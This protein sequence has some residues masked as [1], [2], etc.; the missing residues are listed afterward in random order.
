MRT[1]KFWQKLTENE[2][3]LDWNG[4]EQIWNSYWK[5][6][7][8]EMEEKKGIQININIAVNVNGERW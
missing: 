5:Q 1:E 2:F 3:Y 6:M 4:E 7:S 8:L